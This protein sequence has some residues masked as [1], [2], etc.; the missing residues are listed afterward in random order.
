MPLPKFNFL[1]KPKSRKL[2]QLQINLE[3]LLFK[4]LFV[5]Q[6]LPYNLFIPQRNL[7]RNRPNIRNPPFRFHLHK[8]A[9]ILQNHHQVNQHFLDNCEALFVSVQFSVNHEILEILV[10]N[11]PEQFFVFRVKLRRKARIWGRK[12]IEFEFVFEVFLE[13]GIKMGYLVCTVLKSW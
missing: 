8:H 3:G 12:C 11:R 13:P 10:K 9:E 4:L 1:Q 5:R 7:L 2:E 6:L